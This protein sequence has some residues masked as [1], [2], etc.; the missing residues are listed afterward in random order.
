M[1]AMDS[2]REMC[3]YFWELL[4]DM[5]HRVECLKLTLSYC[6]VSYVIT[7]TDMTGE[8]SIPKEKP[9][10]PCGEVKFRNIQPKISSDIWGLCY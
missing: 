2:F 3:G 1:F 6:R 7:V 9:R 4:D 8:V 5:F 10:P